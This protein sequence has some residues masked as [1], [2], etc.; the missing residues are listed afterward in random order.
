MLRRAFTRLTR[1]R[2]LGALLC[3]SLLAGAALFSVMAIPAAA[4]A[5]A[6][7]LTVRAVSAPGDD[8]K[9][10]GGTTI[11]YSNCAEGYIMVNYGGGGNK[12]KLQITGPNAVT[13]TYNLSKGKGYVAFPLTAGDGSYSINVMEN[14]VASQYA[15][16]LSASVSV[17]LN[18]S[19]LPFLYPSQYVGFTAQSAAV[20]KGEE[21]AASAGTELQVVE[22][23]YNYVTSNI[24]YDDDKVSTVTTTYL[25]D[26]DDTLSTKKGICF[27]YAALMT[28]MLRT[29]NIPTRLEVG[30]VSGGIYHAWVSVY[31]TEVGWVN[32][33]IQ[34]DGTTWKLMDPTF[35][36]GGSSQFVGNGSNYSTKYIY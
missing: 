28:A 19:L 4:A 15:V 27:D 24:T 3:C 26:I 23:V 2:R 30:Y 5:R 21:L 20:A 14:V 33:I 32:N 16:A 8:I 18:S 1:A 10:G 13:Y 29:Q 25:P 12:V 22:A 6:T 17:K 36:A 31:L 35:A 7:A 11:D 34:F 9:S